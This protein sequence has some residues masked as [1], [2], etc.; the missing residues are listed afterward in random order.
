ML[1]LVL[2][3]GVIHVVTI[4]V[5]SADHE[6]NGVADF[7]TQTDPEVRK[8]TLTIGNIISKNTIKEI[9]LESE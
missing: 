9:T 3:V 6:R 5:I 2:D 4:M 1:F 7:F 8:V